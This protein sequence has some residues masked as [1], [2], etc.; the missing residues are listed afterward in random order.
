MV[1]VALNGQLTC[2]CC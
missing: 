1:R 2:R